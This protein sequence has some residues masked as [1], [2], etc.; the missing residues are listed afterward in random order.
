MYKPFLEVCGKE[1]LRKIDQLCNH[2]LRKVVT[3]C[4]S[5]PL[6]SLLI[7]LVK[8]FIVRSARNQELC[9][10][11]VKFAFMINCH[12]GIEIPYFSSECFPSICIYCGSEEN[13]VPAIEM[14]G[15]FPLCSSCKA[16]IPGILKR[17][18]KLCSSNFF[19]TLF[20]L[21]FA[22]KEYLFYILV[23]IL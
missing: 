16:T 2:L 22:T 5:I 8:F 12:S 1:P 6:G 17:K 14:E 23:F 4:H 7:M 9:M 21:T 3:E 20:I 10:L 18:R 13:L 19:L 11:L 15:M